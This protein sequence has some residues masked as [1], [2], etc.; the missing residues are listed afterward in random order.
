MRREKT[1]S[2]IRYT[3]HYI[4]NLSHEDDLYATSTTPVRVGQIG[5]KAHLLFQKD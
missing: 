4:D 1:K 5:E 3:Y 2:D